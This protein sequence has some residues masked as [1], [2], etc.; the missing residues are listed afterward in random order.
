MDANTVRE[1]VDRGPDKVGYPDLKE[2]KDRNIM[3]TFGWDGNDYVWH[4]GTTHHRVRFS[5][6][7]EQMLYTI[8]KSMNKVIPKTCKVDIFLPSK[9]WDLKIYT[10]KAWGLRE[11]WQITEELLNNLLRDLLSQLNSFSFI[12]R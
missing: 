12:G 11:C 4:I 3:I 8:I 10:F 1:Q 5:V 6:T 9:D 7:E 2:A